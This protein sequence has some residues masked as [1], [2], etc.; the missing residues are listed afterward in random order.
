ML[1]SSLGPAL[2]PI[3]STGKKGD[4]PPKGEHWA[5]LNQS[6]LRAICAA[7]IITMFVSTGVDA[8]VLTK[9]FGFAA[10]DFLPSIPAP[11]QTTV[12]GR[13]TLT[14]DPAL[15][16]SSNEARPDSISLSIGGH[17]YS[18]DEVSFVQGG[19]PNVARQFEIGVPPISI[20]IIP[21]NDFVLNFTYDPVTDTVL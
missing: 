13:I 17:I 9:T 19:P 4:S 10:T 18:V 2:G 8:S 21:E 14:F 5:M 15:L 1:P 7:A 16:G 11:P 20:L 12:S 6:V 3:D